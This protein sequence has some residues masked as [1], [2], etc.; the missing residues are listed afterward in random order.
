MAS[1]L[2]RGA[3]ARGKKIAFGDGRRIIWDKNSEPI[4]RGNPNVATPG[5]EGGKGI[6]WVAFYKGN[7]IYNKQDHAKNRWVWNYDFHAKPGEIYLDKYE[8]TAG[9]RYGSGFII[10]EPN[11]EWW[12]SVAPNKDWGRDNYQAVVSMLVREGYKV[13]QF[14]YE[15]S[16]VPLDGVKSLPTKSFRDALAIL[17]SSTLYIGPEGGMHHGAAA[18]NIPG[19]VIFGGFI[20]PSVTGYSTHTNL[21]GG[22]EACGSLSA[23]AHCRE[24]MKRITPDEVFEAARERL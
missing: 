2:A 13:G 23:C 9:D 21:T 16:G 17:S 5:M 11:V 12:K 18:V 6:E 19:V 3:A 1:G 7:R 4:F 20:P 15:K 24:A 14:A 10:V 22:A 8:R